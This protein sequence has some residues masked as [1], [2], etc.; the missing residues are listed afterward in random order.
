MQKPPL[1]VYFAMSN[2]HFKNHGALD[3]TVTIMELRKPINVMP[4]KLP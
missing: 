2:N 4:T 3:V 1:N